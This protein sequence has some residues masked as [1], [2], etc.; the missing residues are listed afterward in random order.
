MTIRGQNFQGTTAVTATPGTGIAIDTAP[1]VSADGTTITLQ[2]AIDT[3]APLGANVIRVT[4]PGG[5]TTDVAN[6]TNT[7]TV[8][9]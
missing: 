8:Q 1:V 5:T 9:P 2:I 3:N 6:Q 4:T 7:F